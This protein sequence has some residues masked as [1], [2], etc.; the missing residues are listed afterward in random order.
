MVKVFLRGQGSEESSGRR[1]RKAGE[2]KDQVDERVL[3]EEARIRANSSHIIASR[4]SLQGSSID[5]KFI[6]PQ[7][8]IAGRDK[9][10]TPRHA[11]KN[12]H[13]RVRQF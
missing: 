6:Y 1:N 10:V 9:I 2:R 4:T 8:Q 5:E 11:K 13:P 3:A 7:M 12:D